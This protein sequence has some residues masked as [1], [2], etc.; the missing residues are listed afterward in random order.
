MCIETTVG[1]VL[2][3]IAMAFN[4]DIQPQTIKSIKLCVHKIHSVS[5]WVFLELLTPTII[6]K[7]IQYPNVQCPLKYA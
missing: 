7:M 2:Y 3:H 5:L 6:C 1:I 4:E